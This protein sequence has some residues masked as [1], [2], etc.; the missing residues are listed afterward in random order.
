MRIQ[1]NTTL[2]DSKKFENVN[3]CSEEELKEKFNELFKNENQDSTKINWLEDGTV[4]V[5]GA[6]PMALHNF[7]L[8]AEA[9]GKEVR[10]HKKT[11][12]EII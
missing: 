3:P 1:L 7:T 5:Q 12:I 10:Y 6:S 2:T 11:I 4:E 9:M 8:Q